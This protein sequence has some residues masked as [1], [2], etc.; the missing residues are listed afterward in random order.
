M[1]RAHVP[2]IEYFPSTQEEVPP[3][4]MFCENVPVVPFTIDGTTYTFFPLGF[5]TVRRMEVPGPGGGAIL[6]VRCSVSE[7]E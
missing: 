1:E 6:P 4:T 7:A 5:W 3:R 2:F